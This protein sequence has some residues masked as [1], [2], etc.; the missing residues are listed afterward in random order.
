M[1][2]RQRWLEASERL[3]LIAVV[4]M[5][6]TPSIQH[7]NIILPASHWLGRE[8]VVDTWGGHPHIMYRQPAHNPLWES[9][10]DH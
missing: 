3:D 7:A 9:K 2:D 8:D 5:H 1:P 6:R 4:G 10:S